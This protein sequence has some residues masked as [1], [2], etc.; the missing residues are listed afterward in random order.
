LTKAGVDVTLVK[1]PGGSHAI[2]GDEVL[3]RVK[4]FFEKHLRGQDVK[5]SDEPIEMGESRSQVRG[6]E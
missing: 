1:I 3:Q 2:G 4:A 6:G 5:V